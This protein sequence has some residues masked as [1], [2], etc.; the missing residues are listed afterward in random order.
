MQTGSAVRQD[1]WRPHACPILATEQSI[2]RHGTVCAERHFNLR[3][4][5]G[6]KLDNERWCQHVPQS[7]HAGHSGKVTIL[8]N[9][10]VQTNRTIPNH[11]PNIIVRD[12]EEGTFVNGHCNVRRQQCDQER[13]R[14]ASLFCARRALKCTDIFLGE[15]KGV[16]LHT[17]KGEGGI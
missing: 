8:W 11:K 5:I 3:E 15:G 9:Q 14:K 4:E 10:Q 12:N 6:V 17:T 1:N 13:S 7:V 2:E 16:L